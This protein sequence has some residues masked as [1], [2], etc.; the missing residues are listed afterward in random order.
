MWI[1]ILNIFS[2]FP[3]IKCTLHLI[4]WFRID[5]VLLL[6]TKA[7]MSSASK[8]IWGC[9][10]YPTISTNYSGSGFETKTKKIC[11]SWYNI[12]HILDL[13][14]NWL[15]INGNIYFSYYFLSITKSLIDQSLVQH[16][17]QNNIIC[18]NLRVINH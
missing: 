16:P 3:F 10:I 8:H 9:Y 1:C 17:A 6:K 15:Y 11:D 2:Y 4:F 7:L 13:A 14:S 18:K 12:D 5:C